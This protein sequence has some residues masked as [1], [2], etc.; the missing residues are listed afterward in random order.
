MPVTQPRCNMPLARTDMVQRRPDSGWRRGFF[1]VDQDQ[2]PAF[3]RGCRSGW[4]RG[5]A[6][7]RFR[8]QASAGRRDP[9]GPQP[10]A[11]TVTMPSPRTS[12]L[13]ASAAGAEATSDVALPGDDD[14]I[15]RHQPDGAQPARRAAAMMV[16]Q[17]QHQI[18]L[19]AARRAQQQHAMAV[20]GDAAAM[21]DRNVSHRRPPECAR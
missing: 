13:P 3:R 18:G 15:V 9:A 12:S 19:A 21:D 2:R 8:Q 5:P 20:D 17:P 4:F 1:G 6:G 11:G 10:R 7:A 16:D 14:L